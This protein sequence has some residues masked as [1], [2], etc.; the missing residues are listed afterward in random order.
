MNPSEQAP[1]S[2]TKKAMRGTD[3]ARH[4]WLGGHIRHGKKGDTYVI[5]RW[6]DG[7]HYHVS[8]KC[9]TEGA[10]LA[11]L[12]VFES[13]PQGYTGQRHGGPD[14]ITMTKDL[15]D[16][17]RAWMVAR[18]KNPSACA[19]HVTSRVRFLAVWM[20]DLAGVDLR[21]VKL[22]AHLKPILSREDRASCQRHRISA[23]KAFYTWLR[24]ERGIVDRGNDPTLDLECPTPP[25]AQTHTTRAVEP[26]RIQKVLPFLGADVRDL[27][28]FLSGTGWHISEARRFARAGEIHRKGISGA[29]AVVMVKHK[30]RR[31]H[32]TRLVQPEHL[33]AAERIR[34]RANLPSDTALRDAMRAACAAAGVEQF[35]L[36]V[37]RHTVATDAIGAGAS[38]KAVSEFLGHD[39]ER[40][41]RRNY[42]DPRAAVQA[43]PTMKLRV[44]R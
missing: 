15:I 42:V 9:R 41:T 27:L 30:N 12:K 2:S 43:V 4:R 13:D 35:R 39:S 7:T 37:M 33:K 17:Y 23:I 40:T 20:E 26:G 10:A 36:G 29:L 28:V 19:E 6:I 8:T 3:P 14:R 25:P 1:R 34:A 32:S 18:A 38:M 16:Q 44:S 5:D 11:Q 22:F 24:K 31:P 21:R